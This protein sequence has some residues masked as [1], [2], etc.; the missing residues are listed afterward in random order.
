MITKEISN[1]TFFALMEQ[2]LCDNGKVRFRVKGVSMQPLLRDDLD[3]VLLQK[4]NDLVPS[5]GDICLF[6]F[7]KQYILHRFIRRQ[8]EVLIMRGDNVFGKKEWCTLPD[9][10]GIVEMVYRGQQAISPHSLK[11]KML[12][13]LH[14]IKTW[15]KIIIVG[16]VHRL[17]RLFTGK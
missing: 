10:V 14:R 12:I 1:D 9:V 4:R 17:R 16:I 5:I 7:G 15:M 6:R 8:G 3:E 11:W 2:V 13:R